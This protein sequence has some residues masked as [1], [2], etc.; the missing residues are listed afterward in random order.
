MKVSERD[1][2][3]Q[4]ARAVSVDLRSAVADPLII[5]YRPSD[6]RSEVQNTGG[7]SV[8]MGRVKGISGALAIWLDTFPKAKGRR[9]SA[10]FQS[11]REQV[12]RDL[13]KAGTAGTADVLTDEIWTNAEN[14]EAQMVRP[15]AA[16]RYRRPLVEI[17]ER[18]GSWKFYTW[19]LPG[20]VNAAAKPTKQTVREVMRFLVSAARAASGLRR[21]D[22]DEI[23][24]QIERRKVRRHLVRERSESLAGAAKIRD[25]FTCQVCGFNFAD[26]YGPSG[27]GLAEA[28]HRVPLKSAKANKPTAVADLITVCANCHRMLHRNP[29]SRQGDIARLKKRLTGWQPNQG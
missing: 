7:W 6:L 24:P 9:V 23:Y 4:L 8:Q 12:V 13:A 18:N 29:I 14:G 26:F 15:L 22:V 16:R 28:H 11:T 27:A 17:Y 25:N 1:W 3:L 10:S 2:L 19:Y 21:A 20:K 5:L